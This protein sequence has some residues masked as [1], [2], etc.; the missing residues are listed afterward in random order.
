M[1]KLVT[2]VENEG[3][4]ALLGSPVLVFC[5]NYIYTGTLTG[6]NEDCIL[7]EDPKIVYQTGAFTD[8]KFEDAQALPNSLYIQKNS[9]ESFHKT[10]KK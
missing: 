9:V 8:S 10:N 6:V 7:L 2:E 1:K 4:M 5:M 3:F